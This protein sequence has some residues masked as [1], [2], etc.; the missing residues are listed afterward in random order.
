MKNIFTYPLLLLVLVHCQTQKTPIGYET[1]TLKIN[2]LTEHTFQ[3]ITY[4]Q[5]ESFGK[6][7]CN[8]MIVIVDGE[9]IVFDTPN[10][11]TE[12]EELI[13]WIEN[14]LQ[15]TIKA[16]VATH[17]HTD[18]LGGLNAFHTKNIPSY[19]YIKTLELAASNKSPIPQNG[20]TDPLEL[21]IGSETVILDHLGEGH[22]LDNSIGY[23]PT[24]QV[25][26][27]GCLIKS[28]GAG[29][30][31]LEDAN[32]A[33][34]PETVSKLKAKYTKASTIIPGHGSVGDKALLDFTI[35]LFSN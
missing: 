24:D 4:L 23:F 20:F 12:S 5:T 21:S 6:V 2:Q 34:W 35:A 25:L 31:N 1:E 9:A 11:D 8:G 10:T 16:V 18:C 29:K 27:G 28:L 32:I 17:F 30:G 26:F 14:E 3:H 19:A 15:C 7:A 33:E 13:Q 22:T